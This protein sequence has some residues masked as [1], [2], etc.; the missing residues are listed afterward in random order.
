MR[1]G[2][3]LMVIIFLL[4]GGCA[5]PAPAQLLPA[6][7]ALY[8]FNPARGALLQM[9]A[10]LVTIG[11]EIPLNLPAPCSLAQLYAAPGGERLA[12]EMNCPSGPLALLINPATATVQ[13]LLRDAS[14]DSH[15]LAWGADGRTAYLRVDS[16]GDPRILA[17][18]AVS[19]HPKRLPLDPYTYDLA[20]SPDGESL[21]FSVSHGLGLGSEMWTAPT[22]GG[23]VLEFHSDE[24]NILGFARWS[25]DEKSIAFIKIPDSQVPYTVGELWLMDA[26]GSSGRMLAAADAGHGYAAAWSPDGG[27]LAFVVRRNPEDSRADRSLG[28]LVSDIYVVEIASG[29]L[30]QVTSHES[31]R[32]ETPVWAPD[33]NTLSFDFVLDGRM[34]VQIADPA[35]SR[36]VQTLE[37]VCCSVWLRK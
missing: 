21:L 18:D 28:A 5:K 36:A 16:L 33:G 26:D 27:R 17:V 11:R 32:A 35:G 30:T 9:G 22:G 29:R 15:F 10:D 24:Q 6:E 4:P 2:L 7:A 1:L 19:L 34:E 23:H 20:V 8:V 31:G 12:A 3:R 37:A 14:V 25:P 13:P